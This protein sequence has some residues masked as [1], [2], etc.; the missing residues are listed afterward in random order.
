MANID[1]NAGMRD[2][3]SIPQAEIVGTNSPAEENAEYIG[4]VKVINTL[5]GEVTDV[6]YNSIT[7]IRQL[8]VELEGSRKAIV[9]AQTKLK[10]LLERFMTQYDEYEFADGAKVR[11][12]QPSLSKISYEA[13]ATELDADVAAL[14]ARV[15][16]TELKNYLKEAIKTGEL[17]YEDQDRILSHVETAPGKPYLKIG[18]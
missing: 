10:A 17:T 16:I 18:D 6:E 12:V 14:F 15:S 1:N 5:T 13:V 9:R 8:Y 2:V 3:D 11:W 7:K 4:K